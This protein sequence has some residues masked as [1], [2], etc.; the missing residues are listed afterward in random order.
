MTEPNG[1]DIRNSQAWQTD[2]DKLKQCLFNER[3]ESRLH[4]AYLEYL[5]RKHASAQQRR[6][7]A[8]GVKGLACGNTRSNG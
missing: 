3:D 2:G 6:T 1:F 4:G 8:E 7:R 5:E